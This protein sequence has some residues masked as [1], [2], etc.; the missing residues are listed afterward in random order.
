MDPTTRARIVDE[1][2]QLLHHGNAHVPLAEA[3]AKLPTNLLNHSVPDLPYT[4]WQLVEHIRITQWDIVEFCLNPAHVSP[5]WPDE[6]WP[7]PDAPGTAE[8]LQATLK[9]I[10][11]DRDR[12][13]A[14]L[15]EP[16]QDLFAPLPQGTGQSLFR[17]AVLIADHTAYHTGQIILV[18]RLLHNWD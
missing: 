14:V 13:L 17:E 3:C 6:Y 2:R 12:F 15:D 18:R 7:G 9:Q 4:L 8:G 10:A 11:H 16:A 1:L 5:S